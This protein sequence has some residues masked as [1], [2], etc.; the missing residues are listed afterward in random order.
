M[1]GTTQPRRRA[2]ACPPRSSRAKVTKSCYG[3]SETGKVHERWSAINVAER[4]KAWVQHTEAKPPE[5]TDMGRHPRPNLTTAFVEP[6]T[7]TERCWPTSGDRNLDSK[8]WHSR[9]VLRPGRTL[10]A[11]RADCVEICDRFQI[12]LPVLKL[13]QAPTVGELAVLVDAG[14]RRKHAAPKR[15]ARCAAAGPKPRPNCRATRRRSRRKA[16]YREFYNDVTRRLE[17]SGMGAASFF[18]NYGYVS[19][20][21]GDE[22]DSK[23]LPRCSIAIRSGWRSS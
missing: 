1:P 22:R 17:Q 6:R 20:G 7:E 16:S 14:S 11:G 23:F 15:P 9:P 12:E 13:F 8:P 5:K 10:T 2:P 19:L 4:L 3:L 18:L 21:E